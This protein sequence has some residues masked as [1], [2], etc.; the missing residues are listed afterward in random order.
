MLLEIEELYQKKI[1]NCTQCRIS[2]NTTNFI[3]LYCESNP[4]HQSKTPEFD[5]TRRQKFF[6]DYISSRSNIKLMI[7]GE[8]PG[9]D[10]CGF[11]GIAFTS[12]HNAVNHLE[13]SDYHG[14][15]THFQRED[16]ADLLYDV[17]FEVAE[18]LKIEFKEFCRKIY[19]TNTSLCIPLNKKGTGIREPSTLMKN[20]C[21]LFLKK[22]IEV[23]QPE[24]I[25]ALGAKSFKMIQKIMNV[26]ALNNIRAKDIPNLCNCI[27]RDLSY[28]AGSTLIIPELHPSKKTKINKSSK[29]LY[30]ELKIRL[31][32]KLL[33][34]FTN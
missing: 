14:T 30:P 10:G 17:F 8:A 23:I 3:N 22:Q 34:I 7:I 24:Y 26:P 18:E 1:F 6:L 33:N 29:K 4:R 15:H 2:K 19:L 28:S 20:R 32:C 21:N 11:S 25:L 31:K 9:L 27:E 5:A 12:E 16:S 13:L